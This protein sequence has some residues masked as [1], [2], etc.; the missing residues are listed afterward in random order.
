MIELKDDFEED[1]KLPPLKNAN[2]YCCGQVTKDYH[3]VRA[4]GHPWGSDDLTPHIV[5]CGSCTAR[6]KSTIGEN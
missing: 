1:Y 3:V 4:K 2:C 6:I 5:Q